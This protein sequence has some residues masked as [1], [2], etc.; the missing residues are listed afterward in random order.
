MTADNANIQINSGNTCN[1]QAG[2]IVII[3][4]CLS[5]DIFRASNVSEGSGK[6]TIAHAN[7][8]NTTNRL[9]KAYGED[10]Q[11]FKFTQK[12]FYIKAGIGGEPA[13][14]RRTNG[15]N[16]QE[17]VTGVEDLQAEYAIDTGSEQYYVDAGDVTD[18]SQSKAVKAT[19][20]TRS[21]EQN[22][23]IDA[24]GNSVD[25]RLRRD[26]TSTMALRNRLN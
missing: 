19:L 5:T 25:N 1:L 8:Q 23:I 9:S 10:A 20:T 6:I 16:E 3:S 22:V 26:F 21:T 24:A 2:D 11:V 13:L 14:H 18:W 12:D 7:N 17:L 4:D 15:T